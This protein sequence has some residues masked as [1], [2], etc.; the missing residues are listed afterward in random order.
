[1]VD[2]KLS[3]IHYIQRFAYLAAFPDDQTNVIGLDASD[4]PKLLRIYSYSHSHF[5]SSCSCSR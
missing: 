2:V 3:T 4:I 5:Y 1:M